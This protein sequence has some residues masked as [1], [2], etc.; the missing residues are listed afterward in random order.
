MFGS[1][2]NMLSLNFGGTTWSYGVLNKIK[3][4]CSDNTETFIQD[5]YRYD[6]SGT[7]NILYRNFRVRQKHI[8]FK[9]QG[10]DTELWHFETKSK[11]TALIT[12]KLSSKTNIGTIC[13][14]FAK[15]CT[16]ISYFNRRPFRSSPRR[17]PKISRCPSSGCPQI[18]PPDRDT[19]HFG[20]R[21]FIRDHK[22]QKQATYQGVVFFE[23]KALF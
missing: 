8:V 7:C 10:Y 3:D 17:P 20:H 9:F 23:F 1:G 4:N 19:T 2:R 13:P 15:P 11:I 5:D 22:I 14:R 21:I 12:P 6:L 16:G 18:L